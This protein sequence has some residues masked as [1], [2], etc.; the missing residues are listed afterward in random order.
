MM[1]HALGGPQRYLAEGDDRARRYPIDVGPFC[2]VP[3][4]PT[5]EHYEALRDLIG[6]GTVAVLLRGEVEVPEGWEVLAPVSAVQMIGPL[7]SVGIPDDPRITLLGSADVEE[8]MSLTSRTK[9]GPF[10]RRTWELGTY[11][12]IRIGGRLVAMAGQRAQ[13][14]DHVEISAVCTDEKFVGQGLGRAMVLAQI[15][16]VV[17]SGKVPMLHAAATNYRAIALYE[18]LGFRHR[19]TLGGVVVRAPV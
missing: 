15:D 5:A 6:P 9:P 11:L 14:N 12:G 7:V 4:E 3:D 18:R 2:A 19:R 1:W 17:A 13:T 10:E 16:A 8:M